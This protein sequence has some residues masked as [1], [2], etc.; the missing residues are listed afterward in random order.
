[1]HSCCRTGADG[2]DF[3]HIDQL[4]GVGSTSGLIGLA[5]VG[6][7]LHLAA[8]D[9]ARGIQFVKTQLERTV[10]RLIQRGL[11]TGDIEQCTHFDGVAGGRVVTVVLFVSV[12]VVSPV[13]ES[14]LE[15]AARDSTI[16][17]AI[18]SEINFLIRLFIWILLFRMIYL[19]RIYRYDCLLAFS[20]QLGLALESSC[21]FFVFAF[22]EGAQISGFGE[23]AFQQNLAAAKQA[24]AAEDDDQNQEHGHDDIGQ[25]IQAGK[26]GAEDLKSALQWGQ[27]FR[28][29]GH[30]QRTDGSADRED[31]PPMMEIWTI[32]KLMLK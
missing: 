25:A 2:N 27:Q 29:K 30:E 22:F 5:V 10:T 4:A 6:D 20:K 17:P 31:M 12:L 9:T 11:A 1:M 3:V 15:Q 19:Q 13:L 23:P 16:V 26:G 24:L 32:S 8:I 21:Q 14:L 18:A 28:Y 7:N